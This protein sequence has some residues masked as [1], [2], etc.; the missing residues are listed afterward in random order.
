MIRLLIAVKYFLVD[1]PVIIFISIKETFG[2]LA[3]IAVAA[4]TAFC[5]FKKKH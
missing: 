4:Y 1:L 3:A 5:L 2:I